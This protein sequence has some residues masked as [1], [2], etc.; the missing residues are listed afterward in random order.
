MKKS[1]LLI[2]IIISL[3]PISCQKDE[4]NENETIE[5]KLYPIDIV[6]NQIDL[7]NNAVF[8]FEI[9]E[10]EISTLDH[11]SSYG[12][13]EKSIFALNDFQLLNINTSNLI[14]YKTGDTIKK[15]DFET[16]K[17]TIKFPITLITKERHYEVYDKNWRINRGVYVIFKNKTQLGWLLFD[18][19]IENGSIKVIDHKTSEVDYIVIQ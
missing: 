16:P 3:T 9:E 5:K 7:D 10:S 13:I 6:N 8:D 4:I 12:L 15:S 14:I 17:H 19:N 18:L 2:I 11:P 1:I